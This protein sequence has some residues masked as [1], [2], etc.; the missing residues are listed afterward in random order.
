MLLALGIWLPASVLLAQAPDDPEIVDDAPG[1]AANNMNFHVDDSTFDQWVFGNAMRAP[2]ASAARVRLESLLDLK[3][4]AVRAAC[5]I[6]ESQQIKLRL[7]GRG[8]V[9]RFF[10]RVEE[11]RALFQFV[12]NDREKFQHF[13]QEVVPLQTEVN[14]GL[15]R[16]ESLFHKTL[17]STLNESQRAAYEMA[18]RERRE[19]RWRAKVEATAAMWAQALG[20]TADRRQKLTNAV[21]DNAR[22]P[23]VLGQFDY[24]FV[25]YK[26]SQLPRETLRPLFGDGPWKAFDQQ[27]KQSQ[28]LRDF[29]KQQGYDVEDLG[30]PK[31]NA[32][33]TVKERK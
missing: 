23:T 12:K 9:K 30:D 5:P 21:F 31:P 22:I 15:F 4:A 32:K 2:N 1:A 24:Y 7:A 26:L 18:E 6:R 16:D 20:L 28:G 19:F 14:R 17:Q 3:I 13:Y 27:L 25:T 33:A 29:L 10:D 8:D 11:K